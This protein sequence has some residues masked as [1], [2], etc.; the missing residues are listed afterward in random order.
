MN[1]DRLKTA[2]EPI[3]IGLYKYLKEYKL[4]NVAYITD[5]IPA[6]C[7]AFLLGMALTRTK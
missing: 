2:Q 5:T 1:T 6:K 7:S 4:V 3:V